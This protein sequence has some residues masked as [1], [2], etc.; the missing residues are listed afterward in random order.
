MKVILRYQLVFRPLSRQSVRCLSVCLGSTHKRGFAQKGSLLSWRMRTNNTK[1]RTSLFQFRNPTKSFEIIV[2]VCFIK[3][4]F[5]TRNIIDHNLLRLWSDR[6]GYPESLRL[7]ICTQSRNPF[8]FKF[9]FLPASFL[10]FFL[11]FV[12][13]ELQTDMVNT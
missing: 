8:R 9:R 10:N 2:I 6:K 1:L 13:C 12:L 11:C 4:S 5:D 3:Y 7:S